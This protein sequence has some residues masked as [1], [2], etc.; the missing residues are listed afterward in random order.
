MPIGHNII[1]Q[2]TVKLYPE[3][4]YLGQNAVKF[5]H[6]S[7]P[8]SSTAG[9]CLYIGH[10]KAQLNLVR[11]SIPRSEYSKFYHANK[12]VSSSVAVCI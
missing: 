7:K 2:S 5:Y 4:V 11:S 10:N 3:G 8:V 1:L 6:V 9:V 12:P